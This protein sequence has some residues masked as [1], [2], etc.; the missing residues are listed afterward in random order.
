MDIRPLADSANAESLVADVLPWVHEAGN[1]Y[2]DWLFDGAH[3]AMPVLAS[4]MKSSSSEVSIREATLFVDSSDD[5]VG[6]FIAWSGADLQKRRRADAIAYLQSVGKPSRSPLMQRMRESRHLFATVEP[7]EFYL[8]KLGV[9]S[10]VRGLGYG[11]ILAD[12]FLTIGLVRGIR[13]F[14]LDVSASNIQAL[15]LYESLGFQVAAKSH[16][17]TGEMTYLTMQLDPTWGNP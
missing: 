17:Q 11:R 12:R 3:V 7:D 1:P 5:A 10:D 15:R 2:F 6:G 16:L 13:R 8:S 9:R 4:R 14:V